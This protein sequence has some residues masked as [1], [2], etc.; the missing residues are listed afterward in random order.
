MGRRGRGTGGDS[1]SFSVT[2]P[3]CSAV[4]WVR[5]DLPQRFW[6]RQ[7]CTLMRGFGWL[8]LS[9][10]FGNQH[11]ELYEFVP[12]RLTI[13]LLETNPEKKYKYAKDI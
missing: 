3:Q 10:S 11:Q 7:C 2:Q 6:E 4:L 8:R 1:L 9:E 13:L 12:F 5:V